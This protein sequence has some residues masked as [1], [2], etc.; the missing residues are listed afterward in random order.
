MD[1]FSWFSPLASSI[2]S[3]VEW[4]DFL[5]GGHC[6]DLRGRSYSRRSCSCYSVV[7]ETVM[8]PYVATQVEDLE[9]NRYKLGL[10]LCGQIAVV[11][12]RMLTGHIGAG[13]IGAVVFVVGNRA[14]CSLISSTLTS[15]VVLGCLVG[16][17]DT[18]DLLQNVASHGTSFFMLPFEGHLIED[19]TAFSLVLA[20]VTELG[21]VRMAWESY[22]QPAFLM[23]QGASSYMSES[24]RLSNDAMLRHDHEVHYLPP[25]TARVGP[26]TFQGGPSVVYVPVG[27]PGRDGSFFGSYNGMTHPWEVAA[28]MQMSGGKGWGPQSEGYCPWP[29]SPRGGAGPFHG[30]P[31]SMM[32]LAHPPTDDDASS[33]GSR[34]TAFSRGVRT[35][36]GRRSYATDT[37][38]PE[39]DTSSP[40]VVASSSAEAPPGR[41]RVSK[42]Q[43]LDFSNVEEEEA[44]CMQCNEIIRQPSRWRGTG[45][46]SNKVYC[47]AC[48]KDWIDCDQ[49]QSAAD[50]AR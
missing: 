39:G 44:V 12:C 5:L 32:S 8:P 40:G 37:R 31:A 43:E 11:A 30:H 1:V 13:A 21:G 36:R 4:G 28:A 41:L 2:Q 49:G 38:S 27:G 48:W 10:A 16:S 15:Y 29:Y 50:A 22:L 17:M 3:A 33:Q 34:S 18:V 25:Q 6:S 47:R 7:K 35:S 45:A 20:P 9:S 19:L 14:R 26:P 24:S 23:G 42:A 46:Y